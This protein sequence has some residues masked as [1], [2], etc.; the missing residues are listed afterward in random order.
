MLSI[1]RLACL[2]MTLALCACAQ[3]APTSDEAAVKA[4]VDRYSAAREGENA[5]A[6][7][8]LFTENADQLVS[9]GEWRR[10]RPALVKGML[11]SSRNNPGNRTIT[12]ETVSFPR[13]GV[14]IANA[15]YEI[16]GDASRP[17]RRMWSTFVCVRDGTAWRI[18]AIRN[19]LPAQ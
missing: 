13:D 10:G 7:D 18:A 19:M 14:A 6:L 11:A 1:F 2:M 9:S 3:S 4:L 8:G 12:V 5:G 17:V 16:A 15:R